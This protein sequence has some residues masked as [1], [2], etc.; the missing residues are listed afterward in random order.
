[1]FFFSPFF[2][3]PASDNVYVCVSTPLKVK[4]LHVSLVAYACLPDPV[5]LTVVFLDYTAYKNI[6]MLKVI[7]RE[8]VRNRFHP[9]EV[10]SP[11]GP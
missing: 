7:V 6:S 10:Q 9:F 2:F 3:L 4:T 1:M 11:R 8:G 5:L